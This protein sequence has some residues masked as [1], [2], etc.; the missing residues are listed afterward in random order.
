MRS[1][2]VSLIYWRTTEWG[3][4]QLGSAR[5]FGLLVRNSCLIRRTDCPGR[6]IT[7]ALGPQRGKA[8]AGHHKI[9]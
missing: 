7:V 5:G 8:I 1:K 4:H 6:V 9:C 2:E 3:L